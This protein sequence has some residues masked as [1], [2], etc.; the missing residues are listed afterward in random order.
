[1]SR[2]IATIALLVIAIALMMANYWYSFGLWP[3]SWTA[4]I[5]IS[6]CQIIVQ[7][8]LTAVKEDA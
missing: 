1:M 4:F 6:L 8:L 3:R 7:L 5:S 2:A